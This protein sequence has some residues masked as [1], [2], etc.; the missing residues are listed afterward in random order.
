MVRGYQTPVQKQ[1]DTEK[2]ARIQSEDEPDQKS[3]VVEI[4]EVAANV[5][6]LN[7]S[8]L[9]ALLASSGNTDQGDT[10]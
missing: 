1:K 3:K 6:A 7:D 5:C 8:R 2:L 9:A 10:S 4:F